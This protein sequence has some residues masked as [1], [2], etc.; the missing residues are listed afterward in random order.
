MSIRS[1]FSEPNY[2]CNR[3]NIAGDRASR[4]GVAA[5]AALLQL[6]DVSRADAGAGVV[7]A[8]GEA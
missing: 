5:R 6:Q 3:E 4:N 1:D 8:A 7:H 2:R